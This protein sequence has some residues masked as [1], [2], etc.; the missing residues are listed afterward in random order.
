MK[1]AGA[2]HLNTSLGLYRKRSLRFRN[3]NNELP[4]VFAHILLFLCREYTSTIHIHSTSIADH[5]QST[6]TNDPARG[7]ACIKTSILLN[8]TIVA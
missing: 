5:K 8:M 3:E 1:S 7:G 4:S 6:L 2:Q